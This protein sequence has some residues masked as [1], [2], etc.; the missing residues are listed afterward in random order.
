MNGVSLFEAD[1]PLKIVD[2]GWRP[3]AIVEGTRVGISKSSDLPL[4]YFIADNAFV[5]NPRR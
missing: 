3:E 2:D 1:S 4:R 5:S